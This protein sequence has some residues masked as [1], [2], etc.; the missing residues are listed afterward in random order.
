MRRYQWVAV[1]WTVV[2]ILLGAS[3]LTLRWAD[4][5]PLILFVSLPLLLLFFAKPIAA[6]LHHG[7]LE[8]FA[9]DR[10]QPQ[11]PLAIMF[12]AWIVLV[13]ETAFLLVRLAG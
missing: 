10:S 3:S 1:G 4:W 11:S 9:S 6:T 13:L 2:N 5:P 8:R 12:I 7:L